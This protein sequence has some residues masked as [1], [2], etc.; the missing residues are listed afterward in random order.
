MEN[1]R[2]AMILKDEIWIEES[3]EE[4]KE[5]DDFKLIEED[6]SFVKDGEKIIFKATSNPYLNEN[7][8]Y[9]IDVE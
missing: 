2:K 5:D 1:V 6:G 9:Q 3:F 7:N 8:I 4:L